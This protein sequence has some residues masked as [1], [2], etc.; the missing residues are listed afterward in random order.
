MNNLIGRADERYLLQECYESGKS[1]FIAIY[2]RRRVGKTFLIKQC[3]QKKFAFYFTGANKIPNRRQL[4]NFVNEM[5]KQAKMSFPKVNS[6]FDAFSNLQILL[7]NLPAKER[8]IIFIDELPWLDGKRSH[9]VS[10]LDYFWNSWASARKDIMLIICGSATSWIIK[11]IIN[12]RGGLHNRLTRQ[13]ALSP[14]TLKETEL[15]LNAKGIVFDRKQIVECYMILGGIPYYLEQLDKRYSLFQNIDNLFFRKTGFLKNEFSQLYASLFNNYENY[16]KVI[17]TL[18]KKRK[19]LTRKELI[20]SSGLPNGGYLTQIL[21]ELEQCG[22]IHIYNDFLKK[23]KEKTYQLVDFYSLFYLNFIKGEKQKDEHYWINQID[24]QKHR[25]WS[26]Y[27]FEQV[28]MMHTKQIKQKLGISGVSTTV[29]SWR[30]MVSDPAV[31]IDLLIHRNDRIT[32]ICEIKYAKD[33]FVI[34]KNTYQNLM[35]KKAAFIAETKLRDAVHLTMLTTYGVKRNE[36][37]GHIQS[38]VVMNDLFE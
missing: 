14:F 1:E 12:N 21:E 36:Y 24:N 34:D 33:E 32:N 37:W 29:S 13:I 26:G 3:F 11:K 5:N 18:S 35:H 4:D 28:C 9:F 22:F 6:W 10:A 31:E 16:V 19:G 30:S 25:A 17:E 38:E 27:A 8:K 15:F 2:G 23:S 7:E 20:D